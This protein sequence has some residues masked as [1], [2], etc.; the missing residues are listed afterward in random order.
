MDSVMNVR[1]LEQA[2]IIG[3]YATTRGESELLVTFR[4]I[5]F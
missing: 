3:S 5:S 1:S 2:L 4:R